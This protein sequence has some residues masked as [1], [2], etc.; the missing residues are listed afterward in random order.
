MGR[1]ERPARLGAALLVVGCAALCTT[2]LPAQGRDYQFQ[3]GR[4]WADGPSTTYE[5]GTDGRLAGPFSH[6][7]AL[8]ALVDDELGRNRAFYGIG[9]ELTAR[10]RGAVTP[11]AVFAAAFG[12][13]SNPEN[14]AVAFIWSTGIGAEWHPLS[15]LAFTAE[16][17]YRIEDRGP[18]GFWR[19]R[20]SSRSGLALTAGIAL[21]FGGRGAARSS[22]RVPLERPARIAGNAADV[23]RT[24][25]DA[26]GAPYRWGGTTENGFDCSGLVQYAYEMHG[27]R[28]P[29]TSRAQAGVGQVV[30]PV[31]GALLPGDILLFA[32][33]PGG[34]VTHVGMYVGESK[35]I[36]SS[37]SGVRLSLL[38][39]EDPEAVW[40]LPRWVGARRVIQ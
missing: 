12:L 8:N 20:A 38:L 25:L 33:N 19:L 15:R 26:I 34:G 32:A 35:F 11:Y 3:L 40:W 36:H 23:V 29:R 18:R 39:P 4:W 27:I 21:S 1:T 37:S 22:G 9:Y 17:R 10:G 24:A 6:G 30:P 7:L 31:V 13:S 28:L 5:L 16:A 14:Q 2:T